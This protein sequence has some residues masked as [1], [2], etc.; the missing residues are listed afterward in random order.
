MNVL[1]IASV[2]PLV[3]KFLLQLSKLLHVLTM[4]RTSVATWP[5]RWYVTGFLH[6]V[7]SCILFSASTGIPD[8]CEL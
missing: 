5:V 6:R 1:T 8:H 4:L 3:I 7:T 2:A